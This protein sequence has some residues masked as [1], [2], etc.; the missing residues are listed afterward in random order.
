[1]SI[2]K[3]LCC[4]LYGD[5]RSFV[6]FEVSRKD[7]VVMLLLWGKRMDKDK[8]WKGYDGGSKRQRTNNRPKLELTKPETSFPLSLLHTGT[9]RRWV[10]WNLYFPRCAIINNAPKPPLWSKELFQCFVL[11]GLF[12]Q[13]VHSLL[14]STCPNP[15]RRGNY[16]SHRH[17]PIPSPQPPLSLPFPALAPTS[18]PP[19]LS[20][21]PIVPPNIQ[22]PNSTLSSNVMPLFLVNS[23]YHKRHHRHPYP[24]PLPKITPSSNPNS[25]QS[26]PKWI[27]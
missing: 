27:L 11:L 16:Q 18:N 12:H 9:A 21:P 4:V 17:P 26:K 22:S 15:Q 13:I 8:D 14:Q 25:I 7:C 24:N 3:M 1:M 6:I 10:E 5:Y 20:V 23:H 19:L 2:F